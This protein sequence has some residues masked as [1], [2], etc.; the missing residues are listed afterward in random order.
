[1]AY[2]D[3]ND[4]LVVY[5][6]VFDQSKWNLIFE[7]TPRSFPTRGSNILAAYGET[8]FIAGTISKSDFRLSIQ[9][10]LSKS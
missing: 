10:N 3:I 5:T 4:N 6:W 7:V 2:K 9:S 1:M 8:L